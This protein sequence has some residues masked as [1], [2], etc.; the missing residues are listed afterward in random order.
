[1]SGIDKIKVKSENREEVKFTLYTDTFMMERQFIL[2]SLDLTEKQLLELIK[3]A[4][5]GKVFSDNL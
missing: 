2:R 5:K 4:I 3:K 1:M